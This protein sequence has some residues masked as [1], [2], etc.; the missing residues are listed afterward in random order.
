VLTC[1]FS[2]LLCFYNLPSVWVGAVSTSATCL[3]VAYSQTGCT[4][5]HDTYPQRDGQAEL[6]CIVGYT[7][8]QLPRCRCLPNTHLSTNEAHAHSDIIIT[9]FHHIEIIYRRNCNILWSSDGKDE[10]DLASAFNQCSFIC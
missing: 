7:P 3:A 2:S 5:T 8:R 6:T 10:S 9:K 4:G 1:W